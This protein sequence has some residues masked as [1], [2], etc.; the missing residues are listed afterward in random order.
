MERVGFEY[1]V[2]KTL[3]MLEESYG[4]AAVKKTQVYEWYDDHSARTRAKGRLCWRAPLMLR[5]LSPIDLLWKGI[6]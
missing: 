5:V 4:E 2:L 1:K 3:R 6:M